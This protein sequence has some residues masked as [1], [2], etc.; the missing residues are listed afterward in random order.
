[1]VFISRI[2]RLQDRK[3]AGGFQFE[4]CFPHELKN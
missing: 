3:P 2:R 4:S 1:V